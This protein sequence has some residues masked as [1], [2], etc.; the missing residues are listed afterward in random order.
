MIPPYRVYLF[1]VDGTLLDSAPDICGAVREALGAE[2]VVDLDE[3]YLRSFV[4]FHL[5]DLFEQVLPANTREQN[6]E[7]LARYRKIYLD[8]KH[9]TTHV[10][11]GVPEMLGAL[12]GL[13]STATTK[14]SETARAVLTQFG[15]VSFFNHVQGTDGFPSKPEPNV[16]IKSLELFGVSPEECL[17]I[18]DAAPDMEAGRRAG[19]KTC[20]VAWGYGDHEAMR[21]HA[22][23]YW[24]SHPKELVS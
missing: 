7:L 3:S 4:G 5:F 9:R 14:G 13:K 15:L 12:G 19:V 24:V 20:G 2:G 16:I 22:P 18:G 1:D 17:L 23:D 6:E 11:D 21:A 8:R 10:Y